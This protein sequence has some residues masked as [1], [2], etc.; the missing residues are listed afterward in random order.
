M[1]TNNTK[2]IKTKKVYDLLLTPII[3]EK[4]K[5]REISIIKKS[6]LIISSQQYYSTADED[7]SDFAI[8]FYKILYGNNLLYKKKVLEN[9]CLVNKEFAGDTMNSFNTIA[10]MFSNSFLW[11][12]GNPTISMNPYLLNYKARYHCLANFWMIP[13]RHGRTSSK[14]VKKGM[15]SY[16]SP[17]LYTE[18]LKAEWD[19]ISEDE[20]IPYQNDKNE[21]SNYF[22]AIKKDDFDNIHFLP[23]VDNSIKIRSLYENKNEKNALELVNI[24]MQYIYDRARLICK[25]ESIVNQL[26]DCFEKLNL[27]D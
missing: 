8:E 16:D 24:S 9:E 18:I 10:N 4:T 20:N 19:S 25:N 17:I 23:E 22:N 11:K 14:L 12:E 3:C 27:I 5:S 26:Y 2:E 6:G 13:M 7:M 21:Y 1:C 15:Y